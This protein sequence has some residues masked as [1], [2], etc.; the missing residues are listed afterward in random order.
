VLTW[1]GYP[2]W[3]L[4][5]L[6]L[7]TI[8]ANGVAGWPDRVATGLHLAAPVMVLAV[9][10]ATRSVLLRRPSPTGAGRREPVPPARWLLAPRSSLFSGAEETDDGVLALGTLV[11]S[12]LGCLAPGIHA[13]RQVLAEQRARGTYHDTCQRQHCRAY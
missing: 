1:T 12:T 5:W 13:Q 2:V 8:A 7:A 6:A 9:I 3:W 10:E 4:R 11:G